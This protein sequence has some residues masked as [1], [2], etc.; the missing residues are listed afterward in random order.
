MQIVNWIDDDACPEMQ[1]W[2]VELAGQPEF[3]LFRCYCAKRRWR[4]IR[5]KCDYHRADWPL[6]LDVVLGAFRD[7]F[8]TGPAERGL[9][10]VC[11]EPQIDRRLSRRRH[12][13]E[14]L[15][16]ASLLDDP[17]FATADQ[18]VNG[19]HRSHAAQQAGALNILF[20]G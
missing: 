1:M 10:L 20:G 2:V 19:Q 17:I 16:A 8:G 6:I 14:R 4:P 13:L 11:V 3:S 7:E 9:V 5:R 18:W 15:F 12:R